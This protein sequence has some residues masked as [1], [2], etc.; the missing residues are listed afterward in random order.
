MVDGKGILRTVQH[1]YVIHVT[2]LTTSD[3]NYMRNNM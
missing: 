1:A 3:M 2:M